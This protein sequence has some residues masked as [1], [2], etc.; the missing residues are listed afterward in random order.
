VSPGARKRDGHEA[1]I[2]EVV[3]FANEVRV[4]LRDERVIFGSV[5]RSPLD[6]IESFRIQPWGLSEST[7]LRFEHVSLAA[8]VK[9]MRWDRHRAIAA[10]QRAGIFA[11]TPR[12][13]K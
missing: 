6:E 10:A 11:G 9:Q 2:R 3:D 13:S 12:G 5:R 8:P 7:K 1:T 4:H